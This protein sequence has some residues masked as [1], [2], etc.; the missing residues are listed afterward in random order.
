MLVV[1]LMFMRLEIVPRKVDH[2]SEFLRLLEDDHWAKFHCLISI[3]SKIL[4]P[5]KLFS[6]FLQSQ[7]PNLLGCARNK[8][9]VL[10]PFYHLLPQKELLKD[11]KNHRREEGK[12]KKTNLVMTENVHQNNFTTTKQYLYLLQNS[13]CNSI[14]TYV[15]L[16]WKNKNKKNIAIATNN[17]LLWT[18]IF[19]GKYL[20]KKDSD[21]RFW[22]QNEF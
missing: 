3:W 20:I 10:P 22:K 12:W 9:L 21:E 19:Y 6:K 7:D 14:H 8:V 16:N 17:S 18:V 1:K 2:C 15:R 4:P 5:P 11:H 13:H